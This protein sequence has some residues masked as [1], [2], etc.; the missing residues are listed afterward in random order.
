VAGG[1]DALLI[2]HVQT[3]LPPACGQD[4]EF[5][6]CLTWFSGDFWF[7]PVF[8][9]VLQSRGVEFST[10]HNLKEDE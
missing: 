6:C 1:H 4:Q 10:A 8:F 5:A 7:S 3:I 2:E 9:P